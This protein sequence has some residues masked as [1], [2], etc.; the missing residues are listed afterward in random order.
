[1]TGDTRHTRRGLL[2]GERFFE[3]NR[4]TEGRGVHVHVIRKTQELRVKGSRRSTVSSGGVTGDPRLV[5]RQSFDKTG[6]SVPPVL[7]QQSYAR[8]PAD[9]VL[10][11]GT[12]KKEIPVHQI[13][14]FCA[15]PFFER[16]FHYTTVSSMNVSMETVDTR[17]KQFGVTSVRRIYF[18]DISPG[19]MSQIVKYCYSGT[20]D[21][22][23]A[24]VDELLR[25]ADMF[26][27]EQIVHACRSFLESASGRKGVS[28]AGRTSSSPSSSS[29]SSWS[30]SATKRRWNPR[31]G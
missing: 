16:L 21:V 7:Y 10:V 12:E 17:D 18:P 13:V 14:L 5:R 6:M 28:A 24:N 31:T 27:I 4:R 8:S 30:S 29:S 11:T 19:V 3:C 2:Y 20:V 23:P 25:V 9:T 1:M 15:T 26:V 22:T